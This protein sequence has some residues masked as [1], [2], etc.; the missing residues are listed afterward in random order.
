MRQVIS[1]QTPGVVNISPADIDKDGDSD[2]FVTMRRQAQSFPEARQGIVWLENVGRGEW[3]LHVVDDSEYFGG[4]RTVQAGDLD[5]DGWLDVLVSDTRMN[6]LAWYGRTSNGR[7][8]RHVIDGLDVRFAHYG[9][10]RDMN[11]DGLLDIVMP[12]R[13]GVSWLEN[14]ENGRQ[15]RIHTVVRF[16]AVGNQ[17]DQTI[18]EVAVADF[19]GDGRDDVAFSTAYFTFSPQGA[20]YWAR[21]LGDD[22]SLHVIKSAW[23]RATNL[24]AAD[25]NGDGLPDI[26]AVGEYDSQV[27]TLWRNQGAQ[28]LLHHD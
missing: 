16:P 17:R 11:R 10:L 19:D 20:L 9:K 26:V 4:T 23:A 24:Q 22:W 2:L 18:T 21:N 27:V 15:W 1:S 13:N 28:D 3:V 25:V 7:W 5:R 8:R 14:V 6:R 12:H